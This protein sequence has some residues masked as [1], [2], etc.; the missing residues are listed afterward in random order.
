MKVGRIHNNLAGGR[1]GV[2]LPWR[3]S[4]TSKCNSSDLSPRVLLS[5]SRWPRATSISNNGV[6][7]ECFERNMLQDNL[8]PLRHKPN[9]KVS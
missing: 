9:T 5:I 7:T 3:Q 8:Q 1:S 6:P 4:I 2:G